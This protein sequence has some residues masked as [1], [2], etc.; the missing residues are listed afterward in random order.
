MGLITNVYCIICKVRVLA[1]NKGSEIACC[2]R[3]SF[4]LY[5][6]F[7]AISVWASE[8]DLLPSVNLDRLGNI[9]EERWVST[10]HLILLQRSAAYA[11]LQHKY[12]SNGTSIPIRNMYNFW[13]KML[14]V[15]YNNRI[16][17]RKRWESDINYTWAIKFFIH[18]FSTFTFF[19]FCVWLKNLFLPQFS[20]HGLER[21]CRLQRPNVD[22]LLRLSDGPRG[23]PWTRPLL[24]EQ[25]QRRPRRWLESWRGGS[26]V[27]GRPGLDSAFG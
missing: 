15:A 14:C 26:K 3:P 12:G 24:L 2:H 22:R 1:Q 23:R 17:M 5:V 7:L 20:R 16:S 4:T 10:S 8:T 11:H 27:R 9:E 6:H 25:Q 19:T 21:C 18:W 13:R